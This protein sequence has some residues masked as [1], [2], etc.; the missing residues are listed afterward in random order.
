MSVERKRPPETLASPQGHLVNQEKATKSCATLGGDTKRRRLDIQTS[1][2]SP[3]TTAASLPPIPLLYHLAITAHQGARQHLQQA[4]I[5][6]SVSQVG[7]TGHPP[8]VATATDE[9][10]SSP[11]T[12]DPQAADKALGLLLLALDCLRM[13]LTSNDLSDKERVAFTLEFGVIGVKV[14]KANS[15]PL[16]SDKGEDRVPQIEV[17]V[18]SLME[19]V[20]DAVASGVSRSMRS[21]SVI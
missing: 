16:L 9:R 7:N 15:S 20:Q 10:G 18:R 14:L 13:G 21:L 12:H 11:F 8:I 5:P 3:P 19:D 2:T 17:E 6:T 1:Y 4:F